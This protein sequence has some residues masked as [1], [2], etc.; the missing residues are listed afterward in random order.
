MRIAKSVNHQIFERKLRRADR[1]RFGWH[2]SS[3][4]V[5]SL[6]VDVMLSGEWTPLGPNGSGAV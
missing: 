3:S 5:F 6:L 4:V 1:L 2:A